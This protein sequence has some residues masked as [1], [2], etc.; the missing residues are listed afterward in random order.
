MYLSWFVPIGRF[1]LRADSWL[2]RTAR[3]PLVL[4]T[5]TF[6]S[7]L[8]DCDH[9]HDVRPFVSNIPDECTVSRFFP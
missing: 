2:R 4:A 1:A 7:F 6:I 5:G 9:L 8:L 3:H